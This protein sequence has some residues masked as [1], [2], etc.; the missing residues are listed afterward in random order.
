[1]PRRNLPAVQAKLNPPSVI[2]RERLLELAGIT[3]QD[4]ASDITAARDKL[5]SLLEAKETKFFQHNG[6][7]EDER[8]VEALDIQRRAAKDLLELAGGLAGKSGSGG[9]DGPAKVVIHVEKQ[10]VTTTPSPTEPTTAVTVEP[11]DE[12]CD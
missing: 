9:A 1:M 10:W 5:L 11:L 4:L 7:V 12:G 6:Q 2:N 3:D 8:E